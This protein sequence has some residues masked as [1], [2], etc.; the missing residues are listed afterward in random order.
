MRYDA[1]NTK[2]WIH[3]PH[4]LNIANFL[5]LISLILIYFLSNGYA[6]NAGKESTEGLHLYSPVEGTIARVYF[7]EGEKVQAGD[8]LY[9][10][11]DK[12][13]LK[14]ID[15]LKNEIEKLNST[16][17]K[18]VG[19]SEILDVKAPFSGFASNINIQQGQFLNKGD[20]LLVLTDTTKLKLVLNFNSVEAQQVKVGQKASVSVWDYMTYVDGKVVYVYSKPIYTPDGGKIYPVE[21]EVENP[22]GIFKGMNGSAEV[23]TP[24]GNI[25]SLDGGKFDY[26]RSTTV[27]AESTL[28]V[29]QVSL[30]QNQY[31]NQGEVLLRIRKETVDQSMNKNSVQLQELRKKLEILHGQLS[32]WKVFAPGDGIIRNMSLVPGNKVA[33]GTLIGKL[34]Y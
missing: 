8:L 25:K 14:K 13:T 5:L 24:S 18:T 33:K 6:F 32:C 26:V 20:P 10:I 12:D 3:R 1:L 9:E 34:Y 16:Q 28:T 30:R 23:I 17:G 27:R 21:I 19:N 11:D 31:I 22:G 15:N 4:W 7:Q 29:E 2:T